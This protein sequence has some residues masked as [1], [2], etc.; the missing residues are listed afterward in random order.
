ILAKFQFLNCNV[1]TKRKAK[2]QCLFRIPLLENGKMVEIKLS[3]RYELVSI[4]STKKK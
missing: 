4:K 3:N 2:K 1:Y